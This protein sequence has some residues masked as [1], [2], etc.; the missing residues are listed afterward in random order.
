MY[1]RLCEANYET[2]YM[3]SRLLYEPHIYCAISDELKD[4]YFAH[5]FLSEIES[6]FR[7]VLGVFSKAE[8]D[9]LGCVHGKVYQGEFTAH[10][11]FKRKVD[12]V[13]GCLLCEDVLRSYC[14]EKS[15]PLKVIAGYPPEHLRVAVL[16]NK[17]YGCVDCG[18]AE[19]KFFYKDGKRIACRN[20]RKVLE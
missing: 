20:M 15:I 12:A 5:R 1:A 7:L 6:G 2:A 11:L 10:T 8:D 18:V 14:R 3:V 19:D 13:K 17:R 9:F 4:V 16:M